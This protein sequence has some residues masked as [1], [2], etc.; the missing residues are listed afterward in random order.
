MTSAEC[1]QQ[2]RGR[3]FAQRVPIAYA[4]LKE[5]DQPSG[6]KF[7]IFAVPLKSSFSQELG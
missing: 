4:G 6:D 5:G 3:H 2:R 7:C 1:S